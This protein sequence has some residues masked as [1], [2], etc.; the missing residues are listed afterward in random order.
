MTLGGAGGFNVD[1]DL[2]CGLWDDGLSSGE[3]SSKLGVSQSCVVSILKEHPNYSPQEGLNRG[4][5]RYKNNNGVQVSKYD[6]DGN[7]IETFATTH[8][9]ARSVSGTSSSI[10]SCCKGRIN[11]VYG[12]QWRYADDAP[13][14][15]FQR[16]RRDWHEVIQYDMD[17][18]ELQRFENIKRASRATGASTSGISDCCRGKRD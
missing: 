5:A 8:D 7:L 2:V 1:Y 4:F 15:K 3:I 10:C 17:W 9:A 13:P 6:M 18:N 14:G 12:F 11:H 16:K